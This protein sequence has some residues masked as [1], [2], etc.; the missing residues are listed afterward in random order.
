MNNEMIEVDH[1]LSIVKSNN[2]RT[3]LLNYKQTLQHSAPLEMEEVEATTA[4]A[5]VEEVKELKASVSISAPIV[6]GM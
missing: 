6:H 5:V 2:L 3:I 1:F 4:A